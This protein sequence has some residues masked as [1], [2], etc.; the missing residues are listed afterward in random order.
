MIERTVSITK[1]IPPVHLYLD[2]LEDIERLFKQHKFAVGYVVPQLKCDTLEELVEAH[3]RNRQLHELQISCRRDSDGGRYDYLSVY[4]DRSAPRIHA[5]NDF[6][7]LVGLCEKLTEMLKTRSPLFFRWRRVIW[8]PWAISALFCVFDLTRRLIFHVRQIPDFALS[9][10]LS[11]ALFNTIWLVMALFL[12]SKRYMVI[13]LEKYKNN[14]SFWKRNKDQI[15]LTVISSGL[16]FLLGIASTLLLQRYTS[17]TQI[18][19]ISSHP[20]TAP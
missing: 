3:K 12:Q 5:S 20:S 16:S 17:P 13:V 2:D 9:L 10:I 7:E 6:S 14:S 4:L 1:A 8:L 15:L 19:D 18:R 11:I